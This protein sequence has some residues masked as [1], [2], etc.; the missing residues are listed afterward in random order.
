MPLRADVREWRA[1]AADVRSAIARDNVVLLA[2]GVAFFALLAIVPALAA[3][4]A[5]WGL[6]A[7]PDDVARV[8]D[9]FA[10]ALPESA[11]QTLEEQLE[12][13]VSASGAGLGVTALVGLVIALWS[14]S[15]ATKYLLQAVATVYGESTEGGYVRFRGL[16]L[17]FTIGAIAFALVTVASIAVLPALL[18]RT[19]LADAT[20][21]AANWLRWPLLAAVMMVALA[22]VYRVAPRRDR[23]LVVTSIGAVAATIVW[24]AGSALFAWYAANFGNFNRTYGSMAGVIVLMLWFF[25]TAFVVVLGAEVNVAIERNA[26]RADRKPG[27]TPAI[28][29]A[30]NR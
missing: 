1:V 13:V 16:A 9:D 22:L 4:V 25:L 21:V 10:A 27:T 7:G 18:A 19:E 3:L 26:G 17:V 12:A 24:V 29:D 5:I 20:R 2:A 8:V 15:T 11:R 23:R 28:G 30:G 14:A 6:F